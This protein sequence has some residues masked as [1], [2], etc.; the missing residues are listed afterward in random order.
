MVPV[1]LHPLLL[2]LLVA[3]AQPVAAQDGAAFAASFVVLGL[4]LTCVCTCCLA[5]VGLNAL[6]GNRVR[7]YDPTCPTTDQPR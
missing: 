2:L 7:D 1:R 3:C 4:I 6:L 5:G